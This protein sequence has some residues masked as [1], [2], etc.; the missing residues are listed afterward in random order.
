[1]FLL[2]MSVEADFKRRASLRQAELGLRT[3]SDG[4]ARQEQSDVAN[5]KASA[6]N[7]PLL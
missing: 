6:D 5:E 2:K 1:V 4:K 3:E 7:M